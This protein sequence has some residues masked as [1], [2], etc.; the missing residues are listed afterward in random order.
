M[1]ISENHQIPLHAIQIADHDSLLLSCARQHPDMRELFYM[2]SIYTATLSGRIPRDRGGRLRNSYTS[3][4]AGIMNLKR[5][6]TFLPIIAC[7]LQRH[8]HIM[9]DFKVQKFSVDNDRIRGTHEQPTL[10]E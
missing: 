2:H 3:E 7:F 9:N 6:C 1:N 5:C 10:L 4:A 8:L